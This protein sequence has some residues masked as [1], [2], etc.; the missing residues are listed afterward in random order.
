MKFID[1]CSDIAFKKIF[2][3]EKHPEVLLSFLNAVLNLSSP[4]VEITLINPYQAP[5]LQFLKETTLDVQAID[6]E[7][8]RFIVEMQMESGDAFGKRSQYYA[9]KSYVEQLKTAQKYRFLQPVYF[10]GV[11]N[12]EMFEGEN[13]QSQHLTINQNTGAQDLKAVEFNFIE[14]PKFNKPLSKL[15]G[16]I[17]QWVYFLKNAEDLKVVPQELAANSEIVSAF[18]IADQHGWTENE[19]NVFEYWQMKEGDQLDLIETR[20]RKS[21]AKGLKEGLNQKAIEIARNLLDV[22]DNA[23][24]AQKTSLTVAEVES[25]RK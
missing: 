24:I 20:E 14:L 5:R 25:L 13:F 3:N 16:I 8:Q 11:L 10:I 9:F 6:A 12:F 19:L 21:R 17:D 15:E 7:G 1:P 18:Q 4:I 23:T 2:G 22:L